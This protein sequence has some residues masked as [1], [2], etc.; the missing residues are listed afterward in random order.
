MGTTLPGGESQAAT[1][2]LVAEP[3]GAQ[4]AIS[5]LLFAAIH[6]GYMGSDL[7]SMFWPMF[8]TAVLGAFFAWSVLMAG[9][10][11]LPV[12]LCHAVL[13]AIVQ[14]WLALS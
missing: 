10:A 8:G 14:P 13:V 7:W 5:A 11:L 6:V 1:R 4:I 2:Q 9:G 3:M 12:V